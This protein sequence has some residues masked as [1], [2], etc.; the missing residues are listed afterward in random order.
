MVSTYFAI[1]HLSAGWVK[2]KGHYFRRR[3]CL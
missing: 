1:K 2:R 3:Q